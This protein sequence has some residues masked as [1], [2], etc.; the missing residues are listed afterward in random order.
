MPSPQLEQIGRVVEAKKKVCHT[1]PRMQR[2][3]QLREY[4]GCDAKS[5]PKQKWME[6]LRAARTAAQAR[7]DINAK[8]VLD[9]RS[10][11]NREQPMN[12]SD[13]CRA[14]MVVRDCKLQLEEREAR[15]ERKHHESK[16]KKKVPFQVMTELFNSDKQY[17]MP[18]FS[19]IHDAHLECL[20]AVDLNDHHT[21]ISAATFEKLYN[22]M[23]TP[24]NL[25]LSG[26]EKS[27]TI[28]VSASHPPGITLTGSS[29]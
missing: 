10:E 20:R 25:A 13:G 19:P 11:D 28:H 17:E 23:R 15:M 7:G 9:T 14:A 4:P 16:Q 12:L 27:G 2:E 1:A 8:H 6:M 5:R 3:L 21:N 22:D 24:M 29:L 18:R 26:F